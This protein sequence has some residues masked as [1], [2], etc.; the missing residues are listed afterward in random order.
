VRERE[1]EELKARENKHGY[2][3]VAPAPPRFVVGSGVRIVGGAF[4][5]R[6]ARYAGEN[7]ARDKIE[8]DMLGRVMGLVLP[9]GCLVAA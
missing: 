6:V 3:C 9:E 8:L 5:G 7:G 1:V 2:V 4:D